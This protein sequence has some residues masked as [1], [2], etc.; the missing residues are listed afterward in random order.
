MDE[1]GRPHS[2]PNLKQKPTVSGPNFDCALL[3]GCIEREEKPCKGDVA[4]AGTY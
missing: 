2:Q 4:L 1:R 3:K